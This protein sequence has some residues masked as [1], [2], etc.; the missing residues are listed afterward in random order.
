VYSPAF[1]ICYIPVRITRV[2]TPPEAR[3]GGVA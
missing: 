3:V 1:G 2:P